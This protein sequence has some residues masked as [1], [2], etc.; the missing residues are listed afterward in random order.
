MPNVCA[1][2]IAFLLFLCHNSAKSSGR[3]ESLLLWP[4]RDNEGQTRRTRYHE[5][6]AREWFLQKRCRVRIS[7][8]LVR[9]FVHAAEAAAPMIES[10]GETKSSTQG[11]A[12][13]EDPTILAVITKCVAVPSYLP[14]FYPLLGTCTCAA[15]HYHSFEVTTRANTTTLLLPSDL[16]HNVLVPQSIAQHSCEHN[17]RSGR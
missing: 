5:R 1:T 17:M 7:K 14:F 9:V 15:A 16:F 8:G 13:P 11:A 12:S 10:L 3:D 6:A 4:I 2:S